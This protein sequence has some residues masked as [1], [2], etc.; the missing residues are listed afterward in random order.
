[1]FIEQFCHGVILFPLVFPA[2][3]AATLFAN[4]RAGLVTLLTCQ[5]IIWYY[6]MPVTNSFELP[7]AAAAV[8]L[9]LATIAEILL[10]LIVHKFQ[11]SRRRIIELDALRI[12]DLELAIEELDHRTMNNFQLAV[13]ILTIEANRIAPGHATEA[14]ER[15]SNRLHVLASV[16]KQLRH[17]S[18]DIRS[19]DLATLIKEVLVA[20]RVQAEN[21]PHVSITSDLE[22]VHLPADHAVS[23]GL[24]A[25][26]LVTNALKH[27][28]PDGRG[29]IHVTLAAVGSGYRLTVTDD[30]VG[31][32]AEPH[33]GSGSRLM[34]MLAR[35]TGGELE[36]ADGAGTTAVLH[37]LTIDRKTA[38]MEAG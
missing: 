7:N 24:I 8:S 10:L 16:H 22:P 11:L 23:S 32:S 33:A 18:T 20:A 21:L 6:L 1:M 31:R 25:N 17:T 9:V 35:S 13:A 19:R 27:A 38:T 28:F 26:E 5:I 30:G 15:A 14:L 4:W 12:A 3:V 29:T 2:V 34:P 37:V 36:Y